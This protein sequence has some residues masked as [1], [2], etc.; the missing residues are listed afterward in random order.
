MSGGGSS[1]TDDGDDTDLDK[2]CPAFDCAGAEEARCLGDDVGET[3]AAH[4]GMAQG[5]KLAI[6]DIFFG[7]YS[8]GDLAGNGLWEACKDA[9]CRIHSNSYGVDSRCKLGPVDLL[10]D[11][12]MY[13]V[14]NV[15]ALLHSNRS[16]IGS[17]E[18]VVTP[19]I[20]SPGGKRQERQMRPRLYSTWY[21][22]HR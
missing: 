4:G 9:G 14:R 7:D 18:R 17:T 13:E 16:C 15:R 19:L 2:L 3:L 8:F 22:R 11:A 12:F 6:F 10:Y 5:A 1:S 21:S 20:A